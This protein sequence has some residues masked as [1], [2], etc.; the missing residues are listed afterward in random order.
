[1]NPKNWHIQLFNKSILK[2]NKYH[3]IN[4]YLPDQFNQLTCLDIGADNGVISYFL[5]QR[6]GTWY[7]ADM[8]PKAV[9]SIQSLVLEN[10]A[11]ITETSTPYPDQIFD[12]IVIIDYLEHTHYDQIFIEDLYRIL[13]P[14]GYL[15]INVPHVKRFSFIRKLRN[16]LG[17][18]D[19][20]HGHVRPGYNIKTLTNILHPKFSIEQFHTYS[21]FFTEFLDTWIQWINSKNADTGNSSKGVMIDE[22]DFQKME[23]KFKLYS[24]LYPIFWIFSK[25]DYLLFWTQGHS[26]IIKALKKEVKL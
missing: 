1:M 24:F 21:K 4:Q 17:L 8:D 13:K 7:S 3:A 20:K 23:K 15:I 22:N 14:N 12:L 6:Q 26:L 19:E 9:Q 5:R 16:T 18:T 25:L 11:Q 2:Q 10:V